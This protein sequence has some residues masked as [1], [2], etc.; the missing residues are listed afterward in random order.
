MEK[1]KRKKAVLIA[2]IAVVI[3]VVA[4]IVAVV[5]NHDS[6]RILENVTPPDSI[7]NSTGVKD[8]ESL[9]VPPIIPNDPQQNPK[10]DS[11][12]VEVDVDHYRPSLSPEVKDVEITYD[13][14]EEVKNE[15]KNN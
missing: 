13:T 9:I 14:K 6:E 10:H 3:L 5:C 8:S 15:E 1:K 4:I 7:E 12:D 11:P 2:L